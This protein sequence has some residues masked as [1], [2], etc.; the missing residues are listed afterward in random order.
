[1]QQQEAISSHHDTWLGTCPAAQC[2]R[3]TGVDHRGRCS[4]GPRSHICSHTC[5]TPCRPWA[6]CSTTRAGYHLV[7]S[8]CKASGSRGPRGLSLSQRPPC[9]RGTPWRRAAHTSWRRMGALRSC[10]PCCSSSPVAEAPCQ[11]SPTPCLLQGGTRL[12]PLG[13]PRVMVYLM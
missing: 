9:S 2:P 8:Q 3:H 10:S 11:P 12:T 7:H 4:W 6:P 5:H 13:S 1:M